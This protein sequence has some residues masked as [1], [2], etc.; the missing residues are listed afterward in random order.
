MTNIRKLEKELWEAADLLRADSKVNSQQYC[1]P[2]LGLIFLRYAFS[3]FKYVEAELLKDRPSRNGRV[4]PVEAADFKTKSAIF[5]PQEARYDWLLNLSDDSDTGQAIN[6]AMELIEKQSPQLSGILPRDYSILQ[7]SILRE[8]LRIFNNSALNDLKDDVIGRI[9]EYFLNKFAPAVASDDGVFFT[10]KSL[11]RMIVNIIEPSRGT[12]FDPA[13]GS[14]GMFVSSADFIERNGINA[15]TAMTFFGQEKVE[16]NAKL[17]IMNMAVHGLSAQIRY[18]DEANSFY[19]DAHNLNGLCDYVMAN[20]PF[21]VDKVKAETCFNAGRLPF[22]LPGVNDKKK[23]VSNGNYLWISYFYSYLNE[24]GRAG[25]VMAAS[26]TDSS[27]KERDIREKLVKTGHVDVLLSVGNNFFYTKTLPCTLWFFDK[28]KPE[29]LQDKVLFIDARNYYTVVDRTLNEWNEWQ[30]KN[31][32]A[33]VWLYRGETWNYSSLLLTYE[34]AVKERWYDVVDSCGILLRYIGE[35]QRT[36]VSDRLS[37]TSNRIERSEGI[38]SSLDIIPE[39]TMF[40][41]TIIDQSKSMLEEMGQLD[42]YEFESLMKELS[43]ERLVFRTYKRLLPDNTNNLTEQINEMISVLTE[44]KFLT[45]CFGDGEYHDIP[46][47]CKIASR[48]EIKEKHW[49]LTP[50]A[51]VGVAEQQNEDDEDFAIRMKQ[52]HTELKAL[53]VESHRLMNTI[54]KNFEEMGL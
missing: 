34:N 11:V 24:H 28:G 15:N 7:N 21:N 51:Y 26:A 35:R 3:R 22:G 27:R 29:T 9:Y 14:G 17:C 44:A 47:L 31:L 12:V 16:Y 13:C 5:L 25:F 43:E 53:Q 39:L 10:P 2:V 18:G 48:A 20:P 46:G 4:L 8:L 19:N 49:S 32:N 50:G 36:I 37:T 41:Q 40:R 52:I 45:D 1:M 23:E 6:H 30:M 54:S 42:K 38:L 33:I